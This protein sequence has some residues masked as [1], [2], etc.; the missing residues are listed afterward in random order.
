MRD[1]RHAALGGRRG[2]ARSIHPGARRGQPGKKGE[3][4]RRDGV[5]WGRAVA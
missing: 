5:P 2:A 1:G 4:P 3:C